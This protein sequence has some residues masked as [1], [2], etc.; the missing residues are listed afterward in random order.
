MCICHLGGNACAKLFWSGKSLSNDVEYFQVREMRRMEKGAIKKTSNVMAAW[1][2]GRDHI[3]DFQES[4][5]R[6]RNSKAASVCLKIYSATV[7][8]R[9]LITC[10]GNTCA[11]G[12][13][14]AGSDVLVMVGSHGFGKKQSI[15]RH[16]AC[17]LQK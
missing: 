14:G 1:K 13:T 3:V 11:E 15:S 4:A 10:V 7:P 5:V 17:D 8:F 9:Q 12:E 6:V 2:R 16:R